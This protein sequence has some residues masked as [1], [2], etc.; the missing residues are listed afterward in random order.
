M[1]GPGPPGAPGAAA[2]PGPPG[3]PGRPGPALSV[4]S[5]ILRFLLFPPPI[6]GPPFEGPSGAGCAP[7]GEAA[8]PGP[9][10]LPGRPGP[11]LS[12]PPAILRLLLLLSPIAG[13]PFEGPGGAEGA[14]GDGLGVVDPPAESPAGGAAPGD[15]AIRSISSVPEASPLRGGAADSGSA[16]LAGAGLGSGLSP[17]GEGALLA[18]APASGVGAEAGSGAGAASAAAPRSTVRVDVSGAAARESESGSGTSPPPQPA[19]ARHAPAI[20]RRPNHAPNGLMV[21]ILFPGQV[22][23]WAVPFVRYRGKARARERAGR[24]RPFWTHSISHYDAS[25]GFAKGA[26]R[27][28]SHDRRTSTGPVRPLL[29]ARSS[30]SIEP[31]F[32]GSRSLVGK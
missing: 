14:V 18:R 24:S 15:P 2:R 29:G 13:P 30:L 22:E 21:V 7:P 26:R 5:T 10:G 1:P 16:G 17:A 19:P 12:V 27:R 3:L 28:L 31:G 4:P 9:P 8:G 20:A 32:R 25:I 23:G 6:A 11:A